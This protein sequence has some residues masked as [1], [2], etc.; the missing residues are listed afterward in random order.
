MTGWVGDIDKN[1]EPYEELQ[2]TWPTYAKAKAAA[3]RN[4]TD[5]WDE[6]YVEYEEHGKISGGFESVGR[7]DEGE[8]MRVYIRDT[9]Q[10][11]PKDTSKST[12]KNTLKTTPAELTEVYII[13]ATKYNHHTDRQ[14]H[15]EITGTNAFTTIFEANH[16]ARHALITKY[17]KKKREE[18]V[19]ELDE[20]NR[21]SDSE[22]YKG[23]GRFI[24][25]KIDTV[26]VE[27]KALK[28]KAGGK[29][30]KRSSVSA[31]SSKGKKARTAA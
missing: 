10:T 11:T 22:L 8:V 9:L 31:G 20:E 29:G 4:L 16:A 18:D 15:M 30:S 17:C 25:D 27:V 3:K 24:A 23:Q 7:F 21:D 5:E 13:T 28:I 12:P 19:T 2:S 26:A 1:V 14:G 6:K